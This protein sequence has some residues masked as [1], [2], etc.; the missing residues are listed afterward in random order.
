MCVSHLQCDKL[1][2]Q[3]MLQHLAGLLL[4][5]FSRSKKEEVQQPR[6]SLSSGVVGRIANTQK[7]TNL[8]N[9]GASGGGGQ[10]MEP[11]CSG[12]V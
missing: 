8:S 4:H 10:R 2:R 9:G 12:T 3:E 6:T 7:G 1:S 5:A 11:L